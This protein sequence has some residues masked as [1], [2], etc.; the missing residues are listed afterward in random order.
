MAALCRPVM[1]NH[2]LC[3]KRQAAWLKTKAF[4]PENDQGEENMSSRIP[5]HF[6]GMSVLPLKKGKT[7]GGGTAPPGRK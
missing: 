3:A 5:V 4:Q 6:M 7:R 1:K 2:V